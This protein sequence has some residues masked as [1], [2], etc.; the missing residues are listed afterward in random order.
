MPQKMITVKDAAKELGRVPSRIRQICI[1]GDADG[2]IGQLLEGKVRV[3]NTSDMR[4]I[5]RILRENGVGKKSSKKVPAR[6]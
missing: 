5:R 2:Q 3:L 4:R 6:T 1:R